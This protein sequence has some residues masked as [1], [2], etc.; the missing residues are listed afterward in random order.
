MPRTR[1]LF[2]NYINTDYIKHIDTHAHDNNVNPTSIKL[3]GNNEQVNAF[4]I[5]FHSAPES[6][7]GWKQDWRS[8]NW[9]NKALKVYFKSY[10]R[11]KPFQGCML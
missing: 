7:P 6:N 11:I 2:Y 3:P 5:E 9:A 1:Y 8:P 4:H 10:D